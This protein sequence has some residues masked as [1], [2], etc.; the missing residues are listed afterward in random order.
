MSRAMVLKSIS[1][2]NKLLDEEEGKSDMFGGKKPKKGGCGPFGYPNCGQSHP[3]PFQYPTMMNPGYGIAGGNT[4]IP[5]GLWNPNGGVLYGGAPTTNIYRKDYPNGLGK[6]RSKRKGGAV[7]NPW[8][9]F[10][11]QM[12]RETGRSYS[13]LISDPNVSALYHSRFG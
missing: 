3:G 1:K 7:A 10:L 6:K 2:L 13:E 12:E 4:M 8:I 5:Y 11:K 9:M